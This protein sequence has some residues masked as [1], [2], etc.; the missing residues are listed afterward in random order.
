MK[1]ITDF[2]VDEGSYEE[3][4]MLGEKYETYFVIRNQFLKLKTIYYNRSKCMEKHT[5]SLYCT[6]K[7]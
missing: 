7:C 5:C 2:L 4:A 1:D 6:N 3:E